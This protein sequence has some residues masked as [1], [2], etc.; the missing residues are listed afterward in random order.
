MRKRIDRKRHRRFTP[1]IAYNPLSA[2]LEDPG[3]VD[4]PV[5]DECE[6]EG[7]GPDK[8]DQTAANQ[9][10]IAFPGNPTHVLTHRRCVKSF[11]SQTIDRILGNL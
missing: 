4:Y 3:R 8:G 1:E 7:Y 11:L 9:C 5:R 6:V 10:D 2:G